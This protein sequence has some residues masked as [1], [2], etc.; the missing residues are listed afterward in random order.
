MPSFHDILLSLFPPFL[1]F[2]LLAVSFI[3]HQTS[4]LSC[5]SLPNL[6]A[7]LLR[8]RRSRFRYSLLY[9]VFLLVSCL[10]FPRP[11]RIGDL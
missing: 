1:R 8:Y 3:M 11:L 4:S 9:S 2:C 10:A 5:T 6:P 7:P